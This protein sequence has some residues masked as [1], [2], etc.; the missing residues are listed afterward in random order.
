MERSLQTFLAFAR[1]PTPERSPVELTVLLR[2]VL[3]L[4]RGRAEKQH[5]RT[6]LE[7]RDGGVTLIA[8]AGQLH[9]VLVNLILNALDAMPTGGTLKLATGRTETAVTVE[10][11]DTGPGISREIMPRLFQPF[12][13]TKDT[14]LGLGLV[15]S[16]RIVEDHGGTLE[17]TNRPGGGACF[18]VRLPLASV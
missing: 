2:E 16:L 5:V 7:L 14:G 6:E 9:Q 3:G 17:A 8:D 4:V 12:A 1:P 15:I 10:V 13:S 11:T 18:C